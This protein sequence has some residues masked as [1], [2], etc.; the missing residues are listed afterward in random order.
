[1]SIR[2]V[3]LRHGQATHNAAFAAWGTAAYTHPSQQDAALT[4]EGVRQAWAAQ[5]RW[6]SDI[7]AGGG[8]AA[9]YCSPLRRCRQTLLSIYPAAIQWPVSLDDRLM[10]PQGEAICNRRAELSDLMT[11]M[12]G[13][14]WSLL[15]VAANNPFDWWVEGGSVGDEGHGRFDAR[16]RDFT[17]MIRSRYSAG[18]IVVVVAHHDWIRTWFRLFEGRPVSLANCEWVIG[19]LSKS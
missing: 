4:P 13:W 7:M 8:V 6:Q 5:A 19:Q 3:F 10:E 9:I 11:E 18:S 17:E 1:M 14:R 2:I 12:A 16:V 15:G